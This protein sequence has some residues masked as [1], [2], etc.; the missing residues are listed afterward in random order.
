MKK[1]LPV[2]LFVLV[3]IAG[4]GMLLYPTFSDWWNQ[5]HQSRAMVEYADAVEGMSDEERRAIWAEADA[6]NRRLYEM[7][8]GADISEEELLA[9]Y[10]NL[11]NV[12][13][14]SMM[15][16][17]TIPKINVRL[18]IR[19]GTD[20]AVL[21][22]SIG[23]IESSSL[24]VGGE[25]THCVVSGH[26]GLPSARLLTDLEKIQIG[27]VFTMEV[28]GVKLTYMVD[29]ILVVLPWQAEALDIRTGEDYCTLVTCTPYGVN[30]HR[31]LVRGVRIMNTYD[32]VTGEVVVPENVATEQIE[33]D[34][35][36]WWLRDRYLPIYAAVIAIV[37]LIIGLI[38]SGVVNR[39]KRKKRLAEQQKQAEEQKQE[40]EEKKTE[41]GEAPAETQPTE[42]NG[43]EEKEPE[44]AEEEKKEQETKPDFE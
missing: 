21:Q 24:P 35:Q 27:D 10:P 9:E 25:N 29:Q 3:F 42:A 37:G 1:I 34:N 12:Y 5:A 28:L 31:L 20:E 36:A 6:Y 43:Q 41:A 26:T 14:D 11:L 18:P 38:I 15:G 33:T 8:R 4:L 13:G 40:T 17:L 30:S 23:H 16:I 32:P 7:H 19:H 2:I 44:E 22:D 39:N